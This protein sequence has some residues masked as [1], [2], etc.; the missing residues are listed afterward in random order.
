MFLGWSRPAIWTVTVCF[1]LQ[2]GPVLERQRVRARLIWTLLHGV[3]G[4]IVR[5]PSVTF[6]HG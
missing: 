4:Q 2:I 6:A 3:A 1:W 5:P